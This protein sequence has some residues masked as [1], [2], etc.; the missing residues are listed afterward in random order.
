MAVSL[1]TECI[2]YGLADILMPNNT[3]ITETVGQDLWLSHLSPTHTL[4]RIE[5]PILTDLQFYSKTLHSLTLS[6]LI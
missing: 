1:S 4:I 5:K 6:G 3:F 2:Q